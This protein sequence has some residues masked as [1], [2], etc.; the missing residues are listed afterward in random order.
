MKPFGRL[1]PSVVNL[2][3]LSQLFSSFLVSKSARQLNVHVLTTE[4]I[5]NYAAKVAAGDLMDGQL[6]HEWIQDFWNWMPKSVPQHQMQT[7]ASFLSLPLFPSTLGLASLDTTFDAKDVPLEIIK[8]L[9]GLDIPFPA[10]TVPESTVDFLRGDGILSSTSDIGRLLDATNT[11]SL[12]SMTAG[13]AATL[14]HHLSSNLRG[15]DLL[16][17]GQK[18]KLRSLP[19]YKVAL[20]LDASIQL[21]PIPQSH[22]LALITDDV[23]LIPESPEVT[24]VKGLTK[25][26]CAHLGNVC[27]EDGRLLRD[28]D[29]IRM[30][31]QTFATQSR[32][33]QM[34][35]LAFIRTQVQRLPPRILDELKLQSFLPVEG[36]SALQSPSSLFDPTSEVAKKL[37]QA[38]DPR[39]PRTNETDLGVIIQELSS[40]QLLQTDLD[41]NL[42]QERLAFITNSTTSMDPRYKV[43]AH[44]LRLIRLRRFDCQGVNFKDGAW[45]PGVDYTLHSPNECFHDSF[46]NRY[47]FD[48]V[49]PFMAERPSDSLSKYAQLDRPIPINIVLEQFSAVLQAAP[50]EDPHEPLI[51]ILQELGRR[52]SELT[53]DQVN[54]L[55]EITSKQPWVPVMRGHLCRTVHAVYRLPFP[56]SSSLPFYCIPDIFAVEP[57]MRDF[58]KSQGCT[59]R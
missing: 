33:T 49:A 48:R 31:V 27:I 23:T 34:A 7:S 16:T 11:E 36:S 45:L 46:H 9:G 26:F 12:V 41:T 58:F 2:D 38:G 4:S 44:L 19:I 24:F 6:L 39:L 13:S 29:M 1:H 3:D 8:I 20:R 25:G 10:E 37:L 47:L 18:Q 30:A 40:L 35:F 14:L 56:S 51:R 43:A 57:K 53:P 50:Q 15:R 22:K 21:L 32:R 59:E 54:M 52:K 5:V 17:A 28:E 55:H 42:V